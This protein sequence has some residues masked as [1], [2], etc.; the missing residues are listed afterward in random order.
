VSRCAVFR[1]SP[2]DVLAIAYRPPL[3]G[4]LPLSQS[5]A[6]HT[7]RPRS[8]GPVSAR[9]TEYRIPGCVVS[10]VT[11]GNLPT[12]LPVFARLA[13]L[14]IGKAEARYSERCNR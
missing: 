4:A 7:T 13:S 5:P 12:R 10:T 14:L 2:A 1:K 6:L 3:R 9:S 11:I 8:G